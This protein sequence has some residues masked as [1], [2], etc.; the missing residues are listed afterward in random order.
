MYAVF[1]V[2][3]P[4]ARMRAGRSFST[5]SGVIRPPAAGRQPGENHARHAPAKLLVDN[6][7]DQGFEIRFAELDGIFADAVDNLR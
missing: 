2:E 6:G 7:L 1:C 4:S 3:R 5:L